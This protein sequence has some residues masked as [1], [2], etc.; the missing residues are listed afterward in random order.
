MKSVIAVFINLLGRLRSCRVNCP[1]GETHNLA[2]ASPPKSVSTKIGQNQ[3][4]DGAFET[5]DFSN[6]GELQAALNI[7]PVKVAIDADALPPDCGVKQG[8][9]A[10]G[11]TPGQFPNT[12]HSVSVA[13]DGTAEFLFGKLGLPVPSGVD[14]KKF[15]YLIFSWSTIG[16]AE[17]RLGRASAVMEVNFEFHLVGNGLPWP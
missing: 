11:G 1:I 12:D 15:C 17:A 2:I 4:N 3:Y 8:W 10:F 9:T 6:E 13:G 14:P 16:F 7:G 5:V